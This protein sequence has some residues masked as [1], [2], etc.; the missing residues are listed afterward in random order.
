MRGSLDY[1]HAGTEVHV[2]KHKTNEKI[3]NASGHFK[4]VRRLL[5]ENTGASCG[6]HAERVL[7]FLCSDSRTFLCKEVWGHLECAPSLGLKTP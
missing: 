4:P 2:W 5:A 7:G 3:G 6:A 1:A